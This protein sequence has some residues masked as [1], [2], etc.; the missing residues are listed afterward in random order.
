MRIIMQKDARESGWMQSDVMLLEKQHTA[1]STNK[2][3]KSKHR[4]WK[5]GKSVKL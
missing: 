2:L 4:D 5:G 1:A 3:W